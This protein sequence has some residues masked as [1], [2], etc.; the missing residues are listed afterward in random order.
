MELAGEGTWSAEAGPGGELRL[1]LRDG[2]ARSDELEAEISGVEFDLATND[3]AA[4][5]FD[6]NQSLRVAKVAMG[7]LHLT[8]VEARFGL[9]AARTLD[10]ER[11]AAKVFGGS[12]HLKPVSIPLLAPSLDAVAEV[13]GVSVSE[14]ARLAPQAVSAGEGRLSGSVGLTWSAAEGLDI[15]TG[16]LTVQKRTRTSLRLAPQ[17][18]FL[19][20]SLPPWL[21]LLSPKLVKDL[22]R[23]ELGAVPLAVDSLEVVFNPDGADGQRTA[24]IKVEGRPAEKSSVRT[25]RL[26]V[27]LSGDLTRVLMLG[28]NDQVTLEF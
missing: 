14:L 5:S 22:K 4:A 6:P 13:D 24:Q 20:N 11:I 12:F 16:T 17:P 1:V 25:V 21:G 19:T 10:V 18:G 15:R 2:W 3:L 23:I 7:N 28:L 27:N 9:S 8:E 26:E